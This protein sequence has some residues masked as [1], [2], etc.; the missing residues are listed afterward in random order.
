[1]KLL[2]KTVFVLVG[3]MVLQCSVPVMGQEGSDTELDVPIQLEDFEI[4]VQEDSILADEESGQFEKG[5]Q[6]EEDLELQTVVAP[7]ERVDTILYEEKESDRMGK[8]T[9]YG[10]GWH[11]NPTEGW[12]FY[13]AAGIKM[14]GWLNSGG[15]WYYLDPNNVEYPGLMVSDCSREIGGNVYGFNSDGSMAVGWYY[16][17]AEGWYYHDQSGARKTG[18]VESYGAWYYLNPENAEYPG[19]MVTD[20]IREIGGNTYEFDENGT[21]KVGW[22][23]KDGEGWYYH[24]QSG[25][26]KTGWVESYGAWYYLDPENVEYPGLMV[27]DCIREIGGNT[28]EF[29]ENGTMKVGWRYKDGEGWYYH[30][31][32]GA[33]KTGWV[34]SYGL[35]YYLDSENGNKMVCDTWKIIG[36]KWYFFENNGVMKTNWAYIYGEWYYFGT[37]GGARIGWQMINGDWYYFYTAHDVHGGPEASMA[38]NQSID[39]W[40]I[41]FDGIARPDE[42]IADIMTYTYVPYVSGGTTPVGWDCSGFTQWA[43]GYLGVNIPRLSH[44]QAMGGTWVDPWNMASWRPGDILVYST[45]G[46]AGHVALYLGDGM[47]MHSLNEKYGTIIQSVAYYDWWD[48]GTYLSGVRRYL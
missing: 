2:K 27:T 15:T 44:E 30:D 1:M 46:Y 19:L 16:R 28:Y 36:G 22:R 4:Q 12:Y 9:V 21:M 23:Y 24:D 32:S 25:A 39:G 42:R 7:E 17:E 43:L 33:R 11:Y 5:E 20:C 35:W 10:Y 3:T 8:D 47:L 45:N 29:D 26:R 13:D 38:A 31:Q 18:W 48:T 6:F 34:Q 37:D 14:M 40:Y 41:G